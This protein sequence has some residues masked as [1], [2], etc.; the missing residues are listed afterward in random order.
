[1]SLS[2]HDNEKQGHRLHLTNQPQEGRQ[3]AWSTLG[4]DSLG[5]GSHFQREDRV[6]WLSPS[7][8]NPQSPGGFP[9]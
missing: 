8:A 2:G 6:P 3:V 9:E 1:M 5:V 7:S 4:E